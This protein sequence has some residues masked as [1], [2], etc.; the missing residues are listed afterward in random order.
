MR[1]R[2]ALC[3]SALIF[4]LSCNHC[5]LF[6][7]PALLFASMALSTSNCIVLNPACA[8]TWAMPLPMVPAPQTQMVLNWLMQLSFNKTTSFGL[9]FEHELFAEIHHPTPGLNPWFLPRYLHRFHLPD[10]T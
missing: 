7:I 8:A 1:W 9:G 6:S 5:R 10:T 3:C 4:P 2:H